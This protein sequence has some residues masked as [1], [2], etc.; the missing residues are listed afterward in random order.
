MK[1]KALIIFVAVAVLVAA[2]GLALRGGSDSGAVDQAE[3]SNFAKSI[4]HTKSDSPS[5][6][7]ERLDRGITGRRPASGK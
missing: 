1:K 4:D 6:P 3:I 5:V 7:K 2:V